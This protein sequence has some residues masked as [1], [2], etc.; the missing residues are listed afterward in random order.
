VAKKVDS[1]KL[2]AQQAKEN[3]ALKAKIAQKESRS[4]RDLE[5]QVDF[6]NE[7]V[8]AQNKYNE[9]L[10]NSRKAQKEIRD[11]SAEIN[12][13]IEYT[14]FNKDKITKEEKKEVGLLVKSLKLQRDQVKEVNKQFIKVQKIADIEAQLLPHKKN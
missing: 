12:E 8:N 11:L 7:M 2:I 6:S 9:A 1:D 3:A 4:T 13:Y 14:H 5:E 10:G